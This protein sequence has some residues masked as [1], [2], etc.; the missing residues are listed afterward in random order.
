MVGGGLSAGH[1][2]PQRRTRD[3]RGPEEP[4]LQSGRL[5]HRVWPSAWLLP[6]GPL[7]SR[8]DITRD[9]GERIQIIVCTRRGT[10]VRDSENPRFLSP[11]LAVLPAQSL[12]FLLVAC[13]V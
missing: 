10:G 9:L 11:S 4:G 12:Q 6:K 2:G 1:G 5:R 13:L 8:S 3:T 7:E